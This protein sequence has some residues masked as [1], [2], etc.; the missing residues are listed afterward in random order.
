MEKISYSAS[1]TRISLYAQM[2]TSTAAKKP[3][4]ASA[5]GAAALAADDK[6]KNCQR[7]KDGDTFTLSIEAQSYR[8][9]G[10]MMVEDGT[11]AQQA[12]E[13]MLGRDGKS[14]KDVKDPQAAKPD[15][16]GKNGKALKNIAADAAQSAGADEGTV[17]MTGAGFVQALMD[18]LEKV[19]GKSGKGGHYKHHHHYAELG[20]SQDVADKLI[21]HLKQ[22]HAEQG[23]SMT[24]FADE[25]KKRLAEMQPAGSRTTMEYQEFRSEV[26]MKLT[27]GL[28]AWVAGNSPATGSGPASDSAPAASGGSPAG[29]SP[30]GLTAEAAPVDTAAPSVPGAGSEA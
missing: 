15:S 6:G 14:L 24:N 9:S 30:A 29:A 11:D 10:T 5:D 20:D 28:D 4:G 23:G 13:D 21:D 25:V 3:Q 27:M 19:A 22:Q 2:S 26:H 18:A 17:D 12:L 1:Y 16:S 7:N 8:I